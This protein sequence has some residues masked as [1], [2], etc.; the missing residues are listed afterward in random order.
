MSLILYP[1]L[2]YR[3]IA[4]FI[5]NLYDVSQYKLPS[6]S[7]REFVTILYDANI[8]A[9]NA[10]HAAQFSSDTN[11][12]F[13]DLQ[14]VELISSEFAITALQS[15]LLNFENVVSDDKIEQAKYLVNELLII[16]ETKS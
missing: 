3:R 4:R 9:Y 8:R 6:I 7:K 15:Y 12:L 13:D 2:Y 16:L 10:I 11:T 14:S 1:V 5:F